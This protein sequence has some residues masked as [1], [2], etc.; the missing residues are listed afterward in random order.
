MIR[1]EIRGN[2]SRLHPE[3]HTFDVIR[4]DE[5]G[6][7]RKVVEFVSQ[8]NISTD[9]ERRPERVAARLGVAERLIRRGPRGFSLHDALGIDAGTT[10]GGGGG[11]E[12][13]RLD[14]VEAQLVLSNVERAY[15]AQGL[16]EGRRAGDRPTQASRGRLE[17]GRPSAGQVGLDHEDG[18]VGKAAPRRL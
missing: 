6:N 12:R 8:V 17:L 16:F 3:A 11:L 5:P 18:H 7:R 4:S 10:A 2:L 15:V 14:H 1:V 9:S 13:R